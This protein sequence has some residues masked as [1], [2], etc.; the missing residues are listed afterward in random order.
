MV[1]VIHISC[2]VSEINRIYSEV[3]IILH[4]IDVCPLTVERY[5]IEM[6]VLNDLAIVIQISIAIFTLMPSKGPLG[7]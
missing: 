6:I 7:H 3:S 4:V 2:D 1:K 5:L